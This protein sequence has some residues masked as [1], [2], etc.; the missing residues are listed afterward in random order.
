ME[1]HRCFIALELPLE[2]KKQLKNLQ[3][4]LPK[5]NVSLKLVEPQNLHLTLKFFGEISEEKMQHIKNQLKKFKSKKF[6]GMINEVGLFSEKF[7][8]VIWVN[9][10]DLNSG[11]DIKKLHQKI[12]LL[13]EEV[14][15]KKNK[16]WKSHITLARVKSFNP[17]FKEK[18]I[19]KI[20]KIIPKQ[21]SFEA[22]SI[23]FKKSRLTKKGPI[24][25]DFLVIPLT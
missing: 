4:I 5:E 24:Y 11:E 17:K 12:E 19:E 9:L 2:V 18:F 25:E 8:K 6:I 21:T 22:L 10:S 16:I 20:K 23:S 14:G 7:V 1:M 15:L 13:T 3:E